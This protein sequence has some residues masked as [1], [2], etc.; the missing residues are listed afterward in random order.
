MSPLFHDAIT[1]PS[2][3]AAYMLIFNETVSILLF[4]C[5]TFA[6]NAGVLFNIKRRRHRCVRNRGG[7]SIGFWLHPRYFTQN[8][9]RLHWY[10]Y[11][12]GTTD[13][14]FNLAHGFHCVSKEPIQQ[15]VFFA[16][17]NLKSFSFRILGCIFQVRPWSKQKTL[18]TPSA[19]GMRPPLGDFDS[20]ITN[21]SPEPHLFAG[22]R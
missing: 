13:S 8:K 5:P 16:N 12:N 10:I 20:V 21:P 15:S 22:T 4:Y 17:S 19:P 9:R 6:Q 7:L 2:V 1:P 3:A 14:S 11:E 18:P